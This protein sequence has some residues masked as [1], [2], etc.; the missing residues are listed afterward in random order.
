MNRVRHS[1]TACLVNF[2]RAAISL[3]SSPSALARMWLSIGLV[4]VNKLEVESESYHSL[5]VHLIPEQ[6]LMLLR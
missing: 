2:S 3:L 1:P 5:R 6:P 4:R